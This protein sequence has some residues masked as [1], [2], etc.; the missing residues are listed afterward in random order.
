M[1]HSTYLTMVAVGEFALVKDAW[2]EI[3]VWY[4]LDQDYEQHAHQIFGNTPEMLEFFS[5]LL[6]YPYPWE[7]YHQIVVKDFVSGAMENTSAVIH[8]DFV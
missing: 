3:P 5:E 4:Y 6:G 2:K 7:K 1:P 8:G